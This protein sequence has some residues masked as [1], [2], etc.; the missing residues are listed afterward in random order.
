[1]RSPTAG[2][3][4]DAWERGFDASQV[5]RGLELLSV[6]CPDMPREALEDLSI[7]ERDALL[8]SLRETAFGHDLTALI[9]CP[10][11][12]ESLEL[13]FATTDLR[14]G[15]SGSPA[16]LA[17]R[18]DGC[19]VQ[20]RRLT[21]RDLAAAQEGDLAQRR[22]VLLERCIVSA[23]IDGAPASAAQLPAAV[24]EAVVQRV[25]EA[26]AQADVQLAV[27]CAACGHAWQVPFD[28]VSFLWTELEAWAARTL[29]EVHVLAS[30]YGWTEREVLAVSPFRRRQYL[31]MV[32]TWPIS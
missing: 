7:G 13:G 12:G 27:S 24:A 14:G 11:C 16:A 20:L 2:E 31:G 5:E 15:A 9:R 32:K 1:M 29:R 26:D 19:E 4:L 8:L 3:F 30:N 22:R 6:A 28:I 10:S 25:A 21:S 17:L 23:H 18:R